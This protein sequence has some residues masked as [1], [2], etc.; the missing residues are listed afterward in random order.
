VPKTQAVFDT[1]KLYFDP[2]QTDEQMIEKLKALRLTRFV[3][4]SR[5]SSKPRSARRRE[6]LLHG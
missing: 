3:A 5:F 1:A 2:N 4:L 6:T